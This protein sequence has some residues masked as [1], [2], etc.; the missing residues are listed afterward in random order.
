MSALSATAASIS[1]A[2]SSTPASK[3]AP[4][5]GGKLSGS[6]LAPTHAGIALMW[7]SIPPGMGTFI[8]F[9]SQSNVTCLEATCPPASVQALVNSPE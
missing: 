1:V 3:T 2:T 7:T 5:S 9:P 4:I 6:Q 8:K